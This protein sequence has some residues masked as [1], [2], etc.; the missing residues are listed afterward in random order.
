MLSNRLHLLNDSQQNADK[1]SWPPKKFI[2]PVLIQHQNYYTKEMAIQRAKMYRDKLLFSTSSNSDS[3][4]CRLNSYVKK[5]FNASK[6]TQDI[7]EI[8]ASLEDNDDPQFILIEGDSGMGKSFLLKEIV[9]QWRKGKLLQRF[10]LVLFVRLCDPIIKQLTTV[11]QLLLLLCK[12]DSRAKE[13]ASACSNCLLQNDGEDLV[14]LL[15]GYDVVPEDLQTNGL[16]AD[17]LKRKVLPNCTII[18]SSRPHASKLLQP[19][20]DVKVNIWGFTE[21]AS[22]QYIEQALKGQPEKT[23]ELMQYLE[24]NSLC[25][26]PYNMAILIFLHS[27]GNGFPRNFAELYKNFVY[28]NICGNLGHSM[29][30]AAPDLN[31]LPEPASRIIQQTSRLSFE[32]II[33]RKMT[34]TQ[35]EIEEACPDMIKVTEAAY[36]YRLLQVEEHYGPP[37]K[38]KT[39]KFAHFSIQEFLAA[40]YI[41]YHLSSADELK[42]LHEIFWNNHYQN[43][44]AFYVALTNGQHSAFK[45]LLSD[46]HDNNIIS[47]KLLDD[48][49]KLFWLFKCFNEAGDHELCR[50]IEETETFNQGKSIE[51]SA[52]TLS[53]AELECITFF[54][55]HTV[56][57][58]WAE[59][60]NLYRCFIQDQGVCILHRGLVGA[61]ITI[62]KLWLDGCNG[63]TPYSLP[64][65]SDIVISCKV[66]V[67]WI[68]GNDII[69]EDEKFYKMV[70]D[71]SSMLESLHIAD[72]KLSS[73]AANHLFTALAV[74]NKLK[75]L[76]ITSNVITD[77]ATNTITATLK[78]NTSLTKLNIGDNPI[79][80]ESA[81][82]IIK[83]LQFNTTLEKVV[84]PEYPEEAKSALLPSV[85]EVQQIREIDE[86]AVK[87]EVTFW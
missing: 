35:D 87:L 47:A 41:A 21:D 55:T 11:E 17:I 14:L 23:Q 15:D 59:G 39:F 33:N 38:P 78:E 48:Q 16:I 6:A 77:E 40:H 74:G 52:N 24:A 63:L 62:T 73:T 44:F 50:C 5:I 43:V 12:G 83:A 65:I 46:G 84:L 49:L 85:Q 25:Q 79:T 75:E 61:G 10:K 36:G 51:L 68:D 81:H 42:I 64:L 80:S 30:S 2:T 9:F 1:E 69:G 32:S 22:K 53:L 7:A 60:I 82:C 19:L 26:V 18:I 28:I 56:Y 20:A 13:I 31:S 66:K 4:H 76:W 86:C 3:R 58:E 45:K 72:A 8:L 27:Y 37:G 54:L 71:S 57:K 70:S 34:F 29:N 67:L